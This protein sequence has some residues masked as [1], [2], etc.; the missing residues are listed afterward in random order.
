MSDRKVRANFGDKSEMVG[1][2][3]Q[4]FPGGASE[5]LNGLKEVHTLRYT[6]QSDRRQNG[7]RTTTIPG[8]A[9]GITESTTAI[10]HMFERPS[11]WLQEQEAT[12]S[13]VVQD[14]L[15]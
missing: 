11:T 10:M 15:S 1:S 7:R 8:D 4:R 9:N 6:Q 14:V 3:R 2:K 5:D 12:T 13:V